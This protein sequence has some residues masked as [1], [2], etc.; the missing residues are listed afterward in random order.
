[1]EF[2]MAP[3]IDRINRGSGFIRILFFFFLFMSNTPISFSQWIP[4][5]GPGGGEITSFTSYQNNIFVGTY[6]AGPFL[7]TNNGLSW[8]L[9]NYGLPANT[10]VSALAVIGNNIF[11]G[12]EDP[13]SYGLGLGIYLSTNNGS[14]WTQISKGL[15]G[16]F[17]HTFAIKG[18]CIFAGTDPYYGGGGGV[19]LSTDNGSNW[20]QVNNG[21]PTDISV[22]SLAVS[23]DNIFAGTTGGPP[24][25]PGGIYLSTDN[26]AN[27]ALSNNGLKYISRHV[28]PSFKNISSQFKTNKSMLLPLRPTVYAITVSGNNIFAG[29]P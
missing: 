2:I 19:F 24:T 3:I 5:N 27:W 22:Y 18:N 21:L 10:G 13:S 20:T 11:A 7:S 28:I 15:T 1:M 6:T 23:G 29:K 14:N 17:I 12:I 4:T 26:G 25:G 8:T 16:T 9:V